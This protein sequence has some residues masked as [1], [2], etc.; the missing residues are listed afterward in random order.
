M[1]SK[2]VPTRAY[3]LDRPRQVIA[4]GVSVATSVASSPSAAGET[5]ESSTQTWGAVP[6][7]RK[8]GRSPA[9]TLTC[10]SLT[11]AATAEGATQGVLEPDHRIG[12]GE[13]AVAD[14][15]VGRSSGPHRSLTAVEMALVEP[16]TPGAGLRARP[17]TPAR[18]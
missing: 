3:R 6:S 4:S 18:E 15:Q 13:R 5:T 11:S 10:R 9:R 7:N 2:N 16:R 1:G 12:A 8:T 14:Q 17:R